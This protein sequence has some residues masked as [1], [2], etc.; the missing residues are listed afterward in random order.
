MKRTESGR[1]EV[2][3]EHFSLLIENLPIV[4][5]A[6]EAEGDFACIQVSENVTRVTGYPAKHFTSQPS[7]WI[8]HV[9][10]EDRER[11]LQ[12]LPSLFEQEYYEHEYRWQAADGSYRWFN[13]VLHVVRSADET[14]LLAPAA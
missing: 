4:H 1:Q 12:E 10:P 11:V 3:E 8:D 13:D 5:Y 9:H 2:S 14:P 6:C 7:F